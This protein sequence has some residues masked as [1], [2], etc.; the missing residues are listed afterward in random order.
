MTLRRVTADVTDVA[1]KKKMIST[2]QERERDFICVIC[3]ICGLVFHHIGAEHTEKKKMSLENHV[4]TDFCAPA[5][6]H[7]PGIFAASHLA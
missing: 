1:D 5:P 2:F 3:V 7:D 4:E 6:D